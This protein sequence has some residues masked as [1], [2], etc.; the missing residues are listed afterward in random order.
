MSL[1]HRSDSN[2]AYQSLPQ[3]PNDSEDNTTLLRRSLELED[4]DVLAEEL[5]TQEAI[6]SGDGR[7]RWIHFVLGCAVLLPWNGTSS[8]KLSSCACESNVWP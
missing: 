8:P 1:H 3:A 7:I 2:A 4:E 6:S 5:V